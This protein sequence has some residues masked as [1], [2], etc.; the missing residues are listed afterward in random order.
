MQITHPSGSILHAYSQAAAELMFNNIK[1]GNRLS[2]D[3]MTLYSNSWGKSFRME[4]QRMMKNESYYN[5]AIDGSF[6]P[7][8]ISAIKKLAAG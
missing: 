2:L 6:S 8:S 5:G 1:N 7:A 3:T 4:L